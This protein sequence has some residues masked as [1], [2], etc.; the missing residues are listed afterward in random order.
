MGTFETQVG[1]REDREKGSEKVKTKKV[2][3][4]RFERALKAY[5][6]GAN[7]IFQARWGKDKRLAVAPRRST[8]FIKIAVYEDKTPSE[9]FA[10]IEISTGDVLKAASWSSP[11][12]HARG[13][14]FASDP[15]DGTDEYGPQ[16]LR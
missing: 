15:L 2:Q 13:N 10:F 3:T 14:I 12:P 7:K 6:D 4:K 5:V 9:V 8:H 11:A 16:S 1:K